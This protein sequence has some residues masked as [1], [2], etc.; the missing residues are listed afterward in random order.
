MIASFQNEL[1]VR[2]LLEFANEKFLEISQTIKSYQGQKN[3]YN[4]LM[5]KYQ[6]L[7]ARTKRAE[8]SHKNELLDLKASMNDTIE[9]QAEQHSVKYEQEISSLKTEILRIR[10]ECEET[11]LRKNTRIAELERELVEAKSLLEKMTCQERQIKELEQGLEVKTF[12]ILNKEREVSRLKQRLDEVILMNTK[13]K[14]ANQ[15]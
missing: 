11:I 5:A 14:Q 12:L 8:L 4:E 2:E 1:I 9:E 10:M 13:L 3:K 15:S 7:E 6:E